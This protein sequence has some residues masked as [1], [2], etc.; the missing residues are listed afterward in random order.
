M[1][2]LRTG[3]M[4]V[5]IAGIMNGSFAL[6]MKRMPRWAWE[7]VWLVWSLAALVVFPLLAATYTVPHL[8]SGYTQVDPAA[9][10]RVVLFGAAW[11]VAQVLFGLSVTAIGIA[12]TF[13]L[14]LGISAAV[15]TVV[16]FVRIHPDLLL[17]KTGAIVFGGV[18][19]VACG[20]IFCALAGQ[21]RERALDQ[22]AACANSGSFRSGLLL[23]VVSGLC[24]SF[25]NLGVSFAGP[26]LRMA[27]RHGAAPGWQL[28]AV[29][30]PLLLGGAVPN[31]LYCSFLLKKHRSAENFRATATTVYW[32]LSLAMGVLWFGGTIL[33][34]VAS[35]DLGTLGPVLGWP[36]F[37]SVI[38]IAASF[39]GWATGEW[40]AAGPRPFRLQLAGIALLMLAV[41]LFSRAVQ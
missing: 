1:Q 12:L 17:S 13:S 7:N 34:G 10:L 33:Y 20:M 31:L 8:F 32:P 21:Q 9:I 29:W 3:S 4:L 40:R 39:L 22:R 15:G 41:F 26:L 35:Y 6:P 11:G 36:I 37:M 5:V 25:M 38:V 2:D 19:L 14:V 23:A 28:N 27:A 30:L 24:A 18:A 16:P